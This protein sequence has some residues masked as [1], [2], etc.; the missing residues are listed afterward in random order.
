MAS[1]AP[2]NAPA[3]IASLIARP[4]C[5]PPPVPLTPLVGRQRELTLACELIQHQQARLLTLTGPGGIGKTRLALQIAAALDDDF[6]GKVAWVPLAAV[7]EA[8]AVMPAIAQAVGI[9]DAGYEPIAKTVQLALREA[10]LLLVLDN[11]EQVL[12]AGPEIADLLSACPRLAALVTSR[13]LLRVAGEQTIPVPPLAVPASGAGT[14]RQEDQTE[15]VQLFAERARAVLPGF[16]LDEAT[17]PIAAEI[18][19]RLEGVPL[20]IELAAARVNHLSIEAL[21]TRLERRL[22][23]LTGRGTNQPRQRTMRDTIAWSYDLLPPP[24]QVLFRQL[25]VFTGGFTLN[26]AEAVCADAAADSMLDALTA[27][28]DKSLLLHEPGGSGGPR[29]RMLETIREYAAEQLAAGDE[30]VA[31]RQRHADYYLSLAEA[32]QADLMRGT[33]RPRLDRLEADYH[34]F[35]A[36]LAWL[37]DREQWEACLRLAAALG[38]FWDYR[39]HLTEGRAWLGRALDPAKTGDVPPALRAQATYELGVLALYQGDYDL[40]EQQLTAARTAWHT[41]GHRSGLAWALMFLG[42]VAEYRGDDEAAWPQYE[43][44]R[45][46]FVDAGDAVGT[47]VAINNLA[48][49]AYRRGDY[50]EADALARAA[51]VVSRE[52]ALPIQIAMVLITVTE[53]ASAL[54]D[55]ARAIAA[56][57]ECLTVARDLGYH[58]GIA[59]VLAGVASV[60]VA[61]GSPLRAARMLGAAN[62]FTGRIGAPRL[63]HQALYQRA[64][65]ATTA[66]L[67]A[68][69]FATAWTA[70]AALTFDEAL[71]EARDILDMTK[72]PSSALLTSRQLEVLRLL[73][74]GQTDREI[75]DALFIGT[76]TVESHVAQIFAKLGVHTRAAAVAAALAA[77]L[78]EPSPP[79]P[80]EPSR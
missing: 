63:T 42:G 76:R 2:W 14:A 47:A 64:L 78:V 24:E 3:A 55:E 65:D 27:L 69:T 10:R 70:G 11:F 1:P 39:G 28:V 62:A 20:A 50:A 23:L 15:A 37:A 16:A 56:L 31:I 45:A 74:A 59:D 72:V 29:Y 7:R 41:L 6:G 75:A 17:S 71:D 40:A 22:Q 19:R 13:S 18:C 54:G 36:A 73:V 79:D 44:A 49:T 77:G 8:A 32:A 52:A 33:D 68:T 51:L 58:F 35:M 80:R 38:P 21:Q 9:D 53:T 30:D 66:A 61:A 4:L 48:D 25:A 67:D 43:E 57:R 5:T 12:A 34:N 46:L 60:A 26:A